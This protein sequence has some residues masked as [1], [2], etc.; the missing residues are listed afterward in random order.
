MDLLEIAQRVSDNL[1]DFGVLL[2]EAAAVLQLQQQPTAE[3][4][5]PA[6]GGSRSRWRTTLRCCAGTQSNTLAASATLAAPRPPRCSARTST[7]ARSSSRTRLRSF[8]HAMTSTPTVFSEA[9]GAPR[10][11]RRSHGPRRQHVRPPAAAGHRD[12]PVRNGTRS[13]SSAWWAT[14]MTRPGP[15]P[16]RRLRPGTRHPRAGRDVAELEHP[17]ASNFRGGSHGGDVAELR[18]LGRPDRL[19]PTPH[20]QGASVAEPRGARQGDLEGRGDRE[21]RH[22]RG[23]RDVGGRS[24]N[25]RRRRGA[26][27]ARGNRRRRSVRREAQP[28]DSAICNNKPVQPAHRPP[29]LCSSHLLQPRLQLG[30]SM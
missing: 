16:L 5:D 13:A 10:G 27:R 20:L 19:A 12:T 26:C 1:D 3:A 14:T 7:P 8:P 30:R 29:S 18:H 6:G 24:P 22:Q 2:A 11:D 4:T 21:H 25:A 17:Q 23:G 15:R 9:P 28:D